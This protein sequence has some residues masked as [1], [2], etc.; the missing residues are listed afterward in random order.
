MN[1]MTVKQAVERE[2]DISLDFQKELLDD[3]RAA[4][5]EVFT[6]DKFDWETFPPTHRRH[7]REQSQAPLLQLGRPRVATEGAQLAERG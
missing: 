2:P 7:R 6:E 4:A 5:P 1:D 3:F